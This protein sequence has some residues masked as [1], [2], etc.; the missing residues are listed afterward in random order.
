MDVETIPK[1]I[2]VSQLPTGEKEFFCFLQT[3]KDASESNNIK[4]ISWKILSTDQE[5][6]NLSGTLP[7]RESE[8]E[9]GKVTIGAILPQQWKNGRL[10]V[11]IQFTGNTL[12]KTWNIEHHTQSNSYCLPFAGMVLILSGHRIGEPHKTASLIPSQHFAWDMLPLASDGLR[13]LRGEYSDSM[14]SQDFA[15]F[16]QAVLAPAAG[17]VVQTVDGYPDLLNVG[18]LPEK[19]DFMKDIRLA[20]GNHVVL[21]H[22]SNVWSLFAHLRQGSV[23]VEKGQS[24]DAGQAIGALGSSGFGSGPHLHFQFMDGPDPITAGP[25][26]IELEIEGDRYDPQSGEILS[27]SF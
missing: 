27:G 25:I 20:L 22:E 9:S 12:K 24:I 17:R 1:R 15:G 13:L 11:E 7:F 10:E 3:Q 5:T 18:K 6:F 4:Q 19:N 14:L 23:S 16:G 26:P 21:K 2:Y 8:Q